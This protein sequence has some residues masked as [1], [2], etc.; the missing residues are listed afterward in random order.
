MA[1]NNKSLFKLIVILLVLIGFLSF[2]VDLFATAK[3][4]FYPYDNVENKTDD[5]NVN[6]NNSEFKILL[7]DDL[8][9]F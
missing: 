3:D 4:I 6:V 1:S 9:I 5:N 7:N 8:F 2:S